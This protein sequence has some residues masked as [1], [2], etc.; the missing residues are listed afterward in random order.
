MSDITMS[1]KDYIIC[2]MAVEKCHLLWKFIKSGVQMLPLTDKNFGFVEMTDEE[3][4][5]LFQK[6]Y[7]NSELAWLREQRESDGCRGLE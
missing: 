2:M 5:E 7:K 4:D 1:E 6:L 3:E